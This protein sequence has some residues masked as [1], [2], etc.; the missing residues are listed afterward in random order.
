VSRES[1]QDSQQG[2]S[3]PP[4][5]GGT[6]DSVEASIQ[7]DDGRRRGRGRARLPLILP[8][9]RRARGVGPGGRGWRRPPAREG[10]EEAP[11]PGGGKG[12]ELR[13]GRRLGSPERQRRGLVNPGPARV[14]G[15]ACAPHSTP[16]SPRPPPPP[17]LLSPAHDPP[18]CSIH[19]PLRPPL[20]PS[21]HL[22]RGRCR[23]RRRR[24]RC[25][26]ALGARRATLVA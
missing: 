20:P 13:D 11:G 21:A 24:R 14:L 26:C 9:Q 19:A 3:L 1:P 8:L 12:P 15:A 16:H 7:R 5:R 25:A 17:R 18:F 22:G 10:M 23:R 4:R 2:V 6:E